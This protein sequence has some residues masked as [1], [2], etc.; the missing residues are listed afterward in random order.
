MAAPTDAARQGTNITTAATSHAINVGS[1]TAGT[2]LIV[3]VRFAGAPG[4]VTFTGYNQIAADTSDASDDDTRVYW[5]WAD[6]NEG[7]TDTLTTG[8]SIKLGAISW[9][10]TGAAVNEEPKI[11]TVNV[12]TTTANTAQSNN[13]APNAAPDDT[14]YI[15][16]AAGDGELL[17]YTAAPASYANLVTANSGSAAAAATNCFM[18]G[19]S[20]QITASSGDDAGVFTHGAHT[21]GWTAFAVAIRDPV[22]VVFGTES[23]YILQGVNR[24]A[25]W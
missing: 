6:G 14:L 10:V 3:F 23:Q 4:A 15:S 2:L 20:R 9:E 5:R 1:P 13:V 22:R 25:V 12:G 21:T 24:G 19:A 16:M 17:A 7:A 18:G 11:S 8:N